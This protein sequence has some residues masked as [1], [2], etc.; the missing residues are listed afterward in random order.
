[1]ENKDKK[2]SYNKIL[3]HPDRDAIVKLLL[4]GKTLKQVEE[5]IKNKYP[6]DKKLH[7][8]HILLHHFRKE[9][10]K[11][12][13]EKSKELQN[14]NEKLNKLVVKNKIN[15]IQTYSEKIKDINKL[16]M[17]YNQTI[18]NILTECYNNIEFLKQNTT[19]RNM[20]LIHNNINSYLSRIHD[21]MSLHYK[22]T[23]DQEK[24]NINNNNIRIE[25]I[26]LEYEA[27]KEAVFETILEMF[28]DY[29][30]KFVEVLK[31]KIENKLKNN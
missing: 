12:D 26:Q 20:H 14:R 18:I 6:N 21:I 7:I 10:L 30:S 8:S 25:K 2:F 3:E 19:P 31:N 16:E 23:K 22:I 1:M 24:N 15:N 27:L 29:Y 5:Y 17:D 28:P 11:E 9:F 13:I 4:E